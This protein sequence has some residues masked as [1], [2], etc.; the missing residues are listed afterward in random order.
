MYELSILKSFLNKETYQKYRSYITDKELSKELRPVLKAF[1]GWYAK[2]TGSPALEDIAN[3]TFAQGI[4]ETESEFTKGVFSTLSGINGEETVLEVLER[5]KSNRICADISLAAYEA[6]EGRRSF[7]EVLELVKELDNPLKHEELDY[8]TDN[9]HEILRETY[10]A[11]GLRWRLDSL[12]KSLGSLRKGNFGFVFARPEC[13]HP[14][15]PV[16]LYSGRVIPAREIKT[17]MAL[18]GDDSTPRYVTSTV[19][20]Q[21]PMYKITYPWGESYTV[22]ENHILSLKRSKVEGNHLYGDVLNVPV[23]EYL[24][25]SEGRKQRYKG[26]KTGV[27]FG[28]QEW[29][30]LDPYF[31]GLWLGDGTSSNQQ[32]TNADKEVID[33]LEGYSQALQLK[34]TKATRNNQGKAL[35]LSFT[36]SKGRPNKLKELLKEY[37]LLDNKHIPFEFKTASKK[38]RQAVL[39]GLIDTDGYYDKEHNGYEI[40]TVSKIL[41]DDVL[42]LARSLGLHAVSK[43]RGNHYRI[44]IYGDLTKVPIRIDRKKQVAKLTTKRKGLQFGFAVEPLGEGEYF[45]FYPNRESFIFIGRLHCYA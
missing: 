11:P 33:W 35:T 30:K 42:F 12:N 1:D 7:S 22:N 43:E 4:P 37:N 20:G 3:L 18:M 21:Q 15:T 45:G 32:I 34:F 2:N 9:I 40:A 41:C 6:S 44:S 39:A 17:G 27:E 19:Y 8:V 14:D 29:H 38:T 25:W 24:T 5:F 13:L 28:S 31:L 36:N 23:K 26:W 16:L 10:I